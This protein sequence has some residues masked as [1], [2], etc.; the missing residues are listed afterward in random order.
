MVQE[1]EHC[2]VFIQLYRDLTMCTTHCYRPNIFLVFVHLYFFKRSTKFRKP[3][4]LPFSGKKKRTAPK[5][6]DLSHRVIEV[7]GQHR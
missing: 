1:T 4:L 2:L 6:L 7:I 5:L 3:A